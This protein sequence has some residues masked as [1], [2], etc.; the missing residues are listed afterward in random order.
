MTGLGN[1][2][3]F[4]EQK[5]FLHQNGT[6]LKGKISPEAN[7]S[8]FMFWPLQSGQLLDSPVSVG[9]LAGSPVG[10][11]DWGVLGCTFGDSP[12]AAK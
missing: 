2:Q 5:D 9:C 6:Q 11:L 10:C 8:S 4:R 7:V 12:A 1:K 3:D